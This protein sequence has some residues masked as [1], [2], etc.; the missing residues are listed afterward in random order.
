MYI[1][2]GHEPVIAGRSRTTMAGLAVLLFPSLATSYQYHHTPTIRQKYL[3]PLR[4]QH[5][6]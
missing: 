6:T 5:I 3:S 2:A 4:L 1:R